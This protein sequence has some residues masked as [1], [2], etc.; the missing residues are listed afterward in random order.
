MGGL[1]LCYGR[2]DYPWHPMADLPVAVSLANVPEAPTAYVRLANVTGEA[3]TEHKVSG[4]LAL[5]TM[6]LASANTVPHVLR[7]R[8][9]LEA[10]HSDDVT[11]L[12]RMSPAHSS[13]DTSDE[14]YVLLDRFS[15]PEVGPDGLLK[16]VTRQCVFP[17]K[18]YSNPFVRD[19]FGLSEYDVDMIERTA[20]GP[21]IEAPTRGTSVT[22]R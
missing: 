3:T 11:L 7:P 21:Y 15:V 9:Q 8:S 14:D 13:S 19:F 10:E 2:Y 6:M 17:G 18:D 5:R 4:M 12:K 22:P 20:G 16:T 1:D